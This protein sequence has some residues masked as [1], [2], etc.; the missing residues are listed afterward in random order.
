MSRDPLLRAL[1]ETLA[2]AE[3]ELTLR[4]RPSARPATSAA[5][6]PTTPSGIVVEAPASGEWQPAIRVGHRVRAGSAIGMLVTPG[7]RLE[8]ESLAGGIVVELLEA[9]GVAVERGHPLL[10]LSAEARS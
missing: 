7:E 4:I 10:R 6:A 1:A 8:V 3:V 9:H 5:D 2:G